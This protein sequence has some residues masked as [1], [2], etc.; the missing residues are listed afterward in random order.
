MAYRTLPISTGDDQNYSCVDCQI[1]HLN[2]EDVDERHW[3]CKHCGYP[4]HIDLADASGNHKLVVRQQAQNL[5]AGH[6]VYLEHDWASGALRVLDS[7]PAMKGNKWYVALQGYC[8][9]TIEPDRYFNCVIMGD[10][11]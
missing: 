6:F 2:S 5:K 9:L 11:V 1:D 8:G 10:M 4:V 3:T 7:K